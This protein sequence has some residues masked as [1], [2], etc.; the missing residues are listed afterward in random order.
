MVW[1][2]KTN[3]E[4]TGNWNPTNTKIILNWITVGSYIY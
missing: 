4:N 1:T 3:E 2:P